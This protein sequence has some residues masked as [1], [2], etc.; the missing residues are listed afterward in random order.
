M[1]R[2]RTPTALSAAAFA[3]HP[4]GVRWGV[5]SAPCITMQI[6]AV[7]TYIGKL[8]GFI[9]EPLQGQNGRTVISTVVIVYQKLL[10]VVK[11]IFVSPCVLK[12]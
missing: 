2:G 11:I 5:Y 3:F 8:A 4:L 9:V 10:L 12:N 1:Q 7:C 6:S